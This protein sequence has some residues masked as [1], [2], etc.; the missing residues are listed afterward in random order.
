[1]PP[2]KRQAKKPAKYD[3]DAEFH[4]D[5]EEDVNVDEEEHVKAEEGEQ[6]EDVKPSKKRKAK[7]KGSTPKAKGSTPQKPQYDVLTKPTETEGGW[8]LHPPSLI[9][10]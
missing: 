9:Y 6:E 2:R 3:D 7:V 1:M 8:T 10:R 4:S 5:D